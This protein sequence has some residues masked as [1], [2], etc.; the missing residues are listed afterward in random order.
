MKH[1]KLRP[2][3]SCVAHNL[4][5][6]QD[7]IMVWLLAYYEMSYVVNILQISSI[8]SV[9]YFTAM[10]ISTKAYSRHAP[11]Q[12]HQKSASHL[13]TQSVE[14]SVKDFLLKFH[15]N[16]LKVFQVDLKA[17]LGLVLPNQCCLIIVWEN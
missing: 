5:L 10:E 6:L 14:N 11:L 7:V 8:I 15:S 1:S 2:S 3:P 12:V 16:F 4:H 17:C 13:L 9:F